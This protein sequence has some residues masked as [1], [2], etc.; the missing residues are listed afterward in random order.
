MKKNLFTI[1]ACIFMA[2]T[3]NAQDTNSSDQIHIGLK[4]GGNYSNIYDTK[5]EKY[6]ADG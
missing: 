5:G 4:A 2:N 6:N 3:M 1:L